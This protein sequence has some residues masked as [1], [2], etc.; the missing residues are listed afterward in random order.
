MLLAYYTTENNLHWQSLP[1]SSRLH[2]RTRGW[3]ESLHLSISYYRDYPTTTPLLYGGT[4]VWSINKASH[5]VINSEQ[6][7]ELLGRWSSTLY[8][9]QNNLKLRVVAAYR[10]CHSPAGDRPL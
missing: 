9:G 1:Q 3:F 5:R 6:D 7:K 2:H 8:Q 10:P 4:S